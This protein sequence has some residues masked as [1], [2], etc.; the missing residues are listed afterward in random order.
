MIPTRIISNPIGD[1]YGRI[2][3]TNTPYTTTTTTVTVTGAVT[4]AYIDRLVKIITEV[5]ANDHNPNEDSSDDDDDA[6]LQ[7]LYSCNYHC[8][9]FG[10]EGCSCSRCGED[11]ACYYI[12]EKMTEEKI[13]KVIELMEEEDKDKDKDKE[14]ERKDLD[15]EDGEDGEDQDN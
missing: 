13:R 14:N 11:S 12:G 3:N 9:S 2:N 7:S 1:N 10:M 4:V 6:S 15:G 5:I 8:H